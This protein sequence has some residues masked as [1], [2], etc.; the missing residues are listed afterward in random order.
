MYAW[1][2]CMIYL[3]T[4]TIRINQMLHQTLLIFQEKPHSLGPID[5][6]C[7]L[8]PWHLGNF[9][10]LRVFER[11][12]QGHLRSWINSVLYKDYMWYIYILYMMSIL[13]NIIFTR[14]FSHFY[15]FLFTSFLTF[16]FSSH[17]I[18]PSISHFYFHFSMFYFLL[19]YLFKTFFC[20]FSFLCLFLNSVFLLFYFL[21]LLL[22][23]VVLVAI[24]LYSHLCHLHLLSKGTRNS[25]ILARSPA[26]LDH[27][28]NQIIPQCKL[29]A[30]ALMLMTGTYKTLT[31]ERGPPYLLMAY[32]PN[33]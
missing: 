18:L 19:H 17:L 20:V 21:L 26:I 22:H 2:P 29:H 27:V 23:L 5:H 11:S 28:A 12:S 33:K 1:D 16:S 7:C 3:P 10:N 15:F 8:P 32:S 9:L 13:Y 6:G 24:W 4:F 14:F 25:R 31:T 30:S